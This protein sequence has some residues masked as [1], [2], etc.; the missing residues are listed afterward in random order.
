MAN[1]NKSNLGSKTFR[2]STE[3]LNN[4]RKRR[5]KKR[6]QIRATKIKRQLQLENRFHKAI[7]EKRTTTDLY[8]QSYI[9]WI[10]NN[11]FIR[12][13]YETGLQAINDRAAYEAW[14]SINRL[15]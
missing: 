13:N 15:K 6:I 7:R 12:F 5:W 2:S 9:H 10:L 4:I 1:H 11:M 8:R 14:L 3:K